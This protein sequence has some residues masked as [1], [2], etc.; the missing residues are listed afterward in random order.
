[1]D[2]VEFIRRKKSENG[3][4]LIELITVVAIVAIL[5]AI[6]VPQFT[7]YRSRA[8]NSSAL[9][10][11]RNLRNDLQGYYAEWNEYPDNS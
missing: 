3:F 11:M 2:V 8:Q 7:K 4:S 9:V 10:D 1:M 5:A 6:A